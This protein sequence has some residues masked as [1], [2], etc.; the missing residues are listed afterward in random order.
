MAI[1]T[2]TETLSTTSE[3][4]MKETSIAAIITCALIV[5]LVGAVGF[6]IYNESQFETKLQNQTPSGCTFL[7]QARDLRKVAFYACGS[8]KEIIMAFSGN[9]P[10]YKGDNK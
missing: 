4:I 1:V 9:Q 2:K 7:G 5:I 10:N 3:V 8:D 6:A